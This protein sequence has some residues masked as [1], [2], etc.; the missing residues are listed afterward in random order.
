MVFGVKPVNTDVKEPVPEPS[1]VL[2]VRAMVGLILVDQTT[3]L[4]IMDAPPTAVILPP[5]VAEVVVIAVMAVVVSVGMET[6]VNVSFRQRME[7][8]KDLK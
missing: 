4:S 7:A 3:P 1:V 6:M 8:P 2:V 5:D